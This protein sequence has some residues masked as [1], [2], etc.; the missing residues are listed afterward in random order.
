MNNIISNDNKMHS[1]T[2]ICVKKDNVI[3][4]V[5]DGQA[6]LGPTIFKANVKK[7]RALQNGK[8]LVGYAGSVS[9]CFTLI[10]VLDS[11]IEEYEDVKR[12]C[13]E[14]SKEWRTDK[15]MRNLEANLIVTNKDNL[16][17]LSGDGTI[18]EVEDNIAAIGSGGLYALS[19]AKAL[20]A[21]TN[22]TAESIAKESMII[23]AN[24]C[25][26]TNTNFTTFII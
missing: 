4:M 23:A 2:V 26:Y 18:V 19:A 3:C 10:N 21:H 7:I 6:S 15:V 9:D 25:I 12:A 20:Y 16:M 8:V 5:A 11:K 24:T 14:L 17:I 22:L 13:Y 1:T